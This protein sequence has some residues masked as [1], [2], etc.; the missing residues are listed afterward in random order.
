MAK[1]RGEQ[2]PATDKGA[3]KRGIKRE[4]DKGG[5]PRQGKL[6]SLK[7]GDDAATRN[8]RGFWETQGRKDATI[9]GDADHS[10]R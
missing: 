6:G 1:N 10:R 5:V 7:K 2:H 9:K 4:A 8:A 3:T